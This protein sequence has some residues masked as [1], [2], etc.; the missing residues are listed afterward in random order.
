MSDNGSVDSS[1]AMRRQSDAV[2]DPWTER[3][4]DLR[5]AVPDELTEG[6]VS[7]IPGAPELGD[8]IEA[9][10]ERLRD[11]LADGVEEFGRVADALDDAARAH[12]AVDDSAS[13]GLGRIRREMEGL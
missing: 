2:W 11:Y 8:A 3:M 9:E 10:L 7:R 1:A 6:A 12:L 4:R 5:T 13:E